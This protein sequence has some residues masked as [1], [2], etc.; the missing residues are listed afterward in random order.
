MANA[1]FLPGTDK[2]RNRH[3]EQKL[4]VPST[5]LSIVGAL[6]NYILPKVPT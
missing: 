1:S 3:T 6:E 4:Y 5:S 2:R